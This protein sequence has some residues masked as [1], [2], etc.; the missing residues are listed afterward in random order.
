MRAK[1]LMRGTYTKIAPLTSSTAP[2]MRCPSA[3]RPAPPQTQSEAMPASSQSSMPISSTELSSTPDMVCPFHPAAQAESGGL[4]KRQPA[5]AASLPHQCVALAA[6]S[7]PHPQAK[8]L[9]AIHRESR[10]VRDRLIL[11]GGRKV[12]FQQRDL[13]QS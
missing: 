9:V 12:A 10:P 6:W 2:A 3:P 7:A 5:R 13:Q 4:A 1:A 11:R 8:P